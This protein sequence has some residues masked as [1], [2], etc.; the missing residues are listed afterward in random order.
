[1]RW[2]LRNSAQNDEEPSPRPF[3]YHQAGFT[4]IEV[5]IAL[6]IFTVALLG[7]AGLQAASLRDNQLAYLN[8]VAVQLARDMGERIRANPE[9]AAAG[10]YLVDN[11]NGSAAAPSVD[12]YSGSCT[13]ADI[14]ATD[15]Y[16]WLT[17]IE[18]RLP[19]GKGRVTASGGLLTVTVMW[20]QERNGASGTGCGGDEEDLA[21][22]QIQVRL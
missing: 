4:L 3:R 13:A 15:A 14:A 18:K 21:C 16:E 5:M 10:A 9:A 11:I 8:T 1:M 2:R 19:T 17:T 20:D 12:C 6:V 7:L 22:L